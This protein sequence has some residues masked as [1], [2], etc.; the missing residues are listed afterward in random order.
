M[1]MLTDPAPYG[2]ESRGWIDGVH[3][4]IDRGWYN[5]S[6]DKS[7][8]I[9]AAAPGKVIKVD[10]RLGYNGGW[11]NRV[12]I[13]HAS[14]C[15]TAYNHF[16]NDGIQ[17]SVGQ[18][19]NAGHYL[20]Q[21]GNTGETNGGEIHLHF[22]LW[23]G[24][25]PDKRVNPQPY[26]T[27][28]LPGTVGP[29]DPDQRRVGSLNANLRRTPDR[30]QPTVDQLAAGT[31]HEFDGWKHGER[32]VDEVDTDI[33]IRHFP[34]G[35]WA[36]LGAMVGGLST[37]GI[38]DLNPLPVGV[39]KINSAPSPD[40]RVRAEANTTSAVITTF[41]HDSN[42]K[43]LGYVTDGAAVDGSKLWFKVDEGWMHSSVFYDKTT[44]DLTDLTE[45]PV[46]EPEPDPIPDPDPVELPPVLSIIDITAADFEVAKAWIK[47]DEVPDLDSTF[48]TNDEAQKYYEGKFGGDYR[49]EVLESHVHWW[50][51]PSAG[52]THDSTVDYLRRTANLGANV[53][54]SSGR[55]TKMI[56]LDR[57][58][59]TTGARSTKAWTT[60]NDPVLTEGGYK[61]LGFVHFVVES[62]NPRL[63][64]EGVFRHNEVIN[65]ETGQPFATQCSPIDT[66]KV[67]EYTEM[68]FDGRLNPVTGEPPVVVTPPSDTDAVAELF[69]KAVGDA[70]K[71]VLQAIK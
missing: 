65:P 58:A 23:L 51:S 55:V 30:S 20:G 6:I 56:P 32:V 5:A 36:W 63:R 25:T 7:R 14:N 49:R 28:D 13:E 67:R 19:V 17:V 54:T 15:I 70:L 39:R 34:S 22:E 40:A 61:T 43:V 8:Q 21:M 68:F 16:M 1:T 24:T 66:A 69:G 45:L 38:P 31:V 33:W 71:D 44:A 50:G 52:A 57:V 27:Q 59:Y 9:F 48:N 4:G 42:V 47:Y 37:A 2:W 18:F 60:E 64:A 53:V 3:R 41:P 46:P 11:G 35:L 26:F 29:I 10:N 62:K 12:W